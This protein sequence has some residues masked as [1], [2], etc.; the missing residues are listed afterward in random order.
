MA[1]WWILSDSRGRAGQGTE[2]A[3]RLPRM[4]EDLLGKAQNFVKFLSKNLLFI[5]EIE[6]IDRSFTP[7]L[8]FIKYYQISIFFQLFE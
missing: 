7:N 4:R 2:R 3:K 5:Q 1:D 6:K 8:H